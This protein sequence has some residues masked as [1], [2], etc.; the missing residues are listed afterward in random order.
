MPIDVCR[1][2]LRE[3][4]IVI[5]VGSP[6]EQTDRDGNISS[7]TMA[8]L[9]GKL[10]GGSAPPP[11]S[12]S[13]VITGGT[14]GNTSP[15]TPEESQTSFAATGKSAQKKMKTHLV[16]LNSIPESVGLGVLNGAPGGSRVRH[17]V[18]ILTLALFQDDDK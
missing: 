2:Y 16:T 18:L 12:A 8:A 10:A 9:R 1:L 17:P 11:G 6:A 14:G 3:M 5:T 13:Q 4:F 7:E 15:G